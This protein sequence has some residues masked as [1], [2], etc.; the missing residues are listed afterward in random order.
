[1][2][3]KRKYDGL[4]MS[5]QAR[6]I[7]DHHPERWASLCNGVGSEVGTWWQKWLYHITP[8]TIW[9]MDITPASDIHDVEYTVPDYFATKF[10]A[11]NYRHDSDLRFRHNIETLADRNWRILRQKR[12]LRA[13]VYY[14]I[15]RQQGAASFYAGKT[16]GG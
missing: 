15:L 11:E 4:A 2:V 8:D 9:G 14:H 13:R 1:M 10:V 16:I 5:P 12:Y 7:L 6:M 3:D